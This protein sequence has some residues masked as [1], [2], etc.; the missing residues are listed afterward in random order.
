MQQFHALKR[1]LLEPVPTEVQHLQLQGAELF[2]QR[3]LVQA[4]VL[5]DERLQ[6]AQAGNAFADGRQPVVADVQKLEVGE[7]ADRRGQGS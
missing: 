2:G 5:G 4:V 6:P 7:K 3:E 1:D